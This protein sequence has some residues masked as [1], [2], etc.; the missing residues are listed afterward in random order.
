MAYVL[1][2]LTILFT[3]LGQYFQKLAADELLVDFMP[4][5]ALDYL[6]LLVDHRMLGALSSL[7]LALLFW[8]LALQGL[9]VSKAYP[10]LAVNYLAMMALARW[11]F[12]E[13]ISR[14]AW[15]GVGVILVGIVLVAGS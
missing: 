9:E 12:G 4:T 13:T 2:A 8:L 1:V 3:V 10:L 14:S 15:C 11:R 5:R 7:A 6:G